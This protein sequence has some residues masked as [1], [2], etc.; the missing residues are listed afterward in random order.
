MMNKPILRL[1][2][3]LA[4]L[5]LLAPIASAKV[6]EA[7]RLQVRVETPTVIDLLHEDNIA[8]AITTSLADTFHR[9]GFDGRIAQISRADDG[10][11]GVP[12]L[13][14][15]V[16]DWEMRP[17]GFVECRISANLISPDGE[18]TRLGSFYGTSVD[19][20]IRTPFTLR[21]SFEDAANSAMR[22]LYRNFAQHAPAPT[23][24][25]ID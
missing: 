13:E 25:L 2:G 23:A 11:A 4:A 8:D 12:V 5:T 3:P 22:D 16:L 7:P 20:G 6:S 17:T 1:L 19:M 14:V 15:T 24:S 18:S 21:R 10:A 9:R